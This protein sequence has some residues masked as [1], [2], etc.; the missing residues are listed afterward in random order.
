MRR[1]IVYSL[2]RLVPLA[3]TLCVLLGAVLLCTACSRGTP[4]SAPTGTRLDEITL[5]LSWNKV[6]GAAYYTV[7]IRPDDGS[8]AVEKDASKPSLSL[9]SLTEGSYE[10]RVRAVAGGSAADTEDS[11]WSEPIRFTREHETGLAFRLIEDGTAFEVSGLGTATGE[12]TVPDTYRG[13]PVTAIGE[14]AHRE[15]GVCQLLLH[16]ARQSPLRADRNRGSGVPELSG[17]GGA[18]ADSGRAFRDR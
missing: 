7:R 2:R 11:G 16:D 1:P 17:T 18:D 3:L 9:E 6:K 4:L 5:T 12:I 14:P 15:A 13:L 10:L 8:D